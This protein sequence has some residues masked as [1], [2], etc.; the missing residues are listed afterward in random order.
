MQANRNIHLCQ[1]K[2]PI[3]K[4]SHIKALKNNKVAITDMR[5]KPVDFFIDTARA[6][7][8]VP[9]KILRTSVPLQKFPF[10]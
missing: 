9:A 3:C 4:L 5:Q 2:T 7:T 6:P 10:L 1:E 8:L